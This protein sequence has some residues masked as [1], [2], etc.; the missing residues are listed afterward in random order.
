M[1][2][3]NSAN[4]T[5][6]SITGAGGSIGKKLAEYLCENSDYKLILNYFNEKDVPQRFKKDS[7]RYKKVTGDMCDRNILARIMQNTDCLIHLAQSVNPKKY[8]VD[9]QN[10][11]FHSSE[12]TFTLFEYLKTHNRKIHLIFPSSG[13]TVYSSKEKIPFKET[14]ALKPI[15]PYGIQ[16]VMFEN[17]L[18]LLLQINPNIT[19]NILRISNPYGS[20]LESERAQ[21]F[22]GIA[23]NKIRSNELIEI[24]G[25]LDYI[26]DY[27]Y[28]DD[29]SEAFLKSISYQN[30]LS[31]FN[32]GSRAGTSLKRILDIL[33]KN[34]CKK[35]NYKITES[36]F[37]SYLPP[38]NVLDCSKAEKELNWIPKTS[39]EEGIANVINQENSMADKCF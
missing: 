22:I 29:L 16:K 11:A 34:T 37:N 28:I 8:A 24:W 15:S 23:L 14:D 10:A 33:S 13:G 4:I 1:S 32:I 6:V 17:Y 38:W 3:A 2:N 19:C 39:I 30:G 9:W 36:G 31:V 26:R 5:T 21:G 35:I 27:L 18:S 25:T 7:A 20:V 12:S